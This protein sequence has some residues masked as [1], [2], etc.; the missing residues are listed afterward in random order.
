MRANFGIG[1]TYLERGDNAK[2]QDIF[3]RLVK[4]EAT[5]EPQ[6]KHLFNEFG[7]NLRKSKMLQESLDYYKR[8]LELSPNDESLYMNIAYCLNSKTFRSAWTF[9][10]K[11]W[12]LRPGM[13]PH[14]SFWPGSSKSNLYTDKLDGV[15]TALKTAQNGAAAKPKAAG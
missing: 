1:L 15:R 7:I 14:S 9:C 11:P 2:A 12:N 10:P 13:K 6:H 3:Q 4:L 8:A 5:F